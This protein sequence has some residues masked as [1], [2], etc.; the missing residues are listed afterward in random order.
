MDIARDLETTKPSFPVPAGAWDCHAHVFGPYE[1]FP[2]HPAAPYQPPLARREDYLAM[3]DAAGLE[4]GVVV[5]P[6]AYGYD[7]RATMDAAANSGKGKIVGVCVIP[8]NAEDALM[9]ECHA[10]GIRGIRFTENGHPHSDGTLPLKLLPDMA[11]RLL[12]RGWHAQVWAKCSEIVALAEPLAKAGV[13]I[14]FDHMGYFEPGSDVS[15][16]VFQRFL[17]LVRDAGFWVKLTPHRVSRSFPDCADV[18]PHHD[19]IVKAIPDRVVWGSDWPFI[20]MYDARP[21]A[22]RQLDLLDRW[23]DRD[24]GLRQK[25]LV[26]NPARF[27]AGGA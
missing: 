14:I 19:A 16:P 24:E 3:L 9:D 26:G 21:D 13:P 20:G 5:H 8:L 6:S 12:E 18:R 10:N 2:L 7:N 17:G 15:D 11:G 4:H 27:Y 1:T 23:N 25:V 22:G